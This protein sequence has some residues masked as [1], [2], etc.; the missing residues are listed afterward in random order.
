VIRRRRGTGG[1]RAGK[2]N[3]S[4]GG[5]RNAQGFSPLS[6]GDTT[7]ASPKRFSKQH[8]AGN[9]SADSTL[10]AVRHAWTST[11]LHSISGMARRSEGG[12]LAWHS[13]VGGLTWDRPSKKKAKVLRGNVQQ[14]KTTSIITY[15]HATRGAASSMR[16]R[17]E[18]ARAPE[19]IIGEQKVE[20]REMYL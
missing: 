14:C 17:L 19:T 3:C 7:T 10:G 13:P 18:A 9:E 8:Q 16:A 15:M 5:L 12:T 20:T 11:H 1:R 4:S 6:R 2:G